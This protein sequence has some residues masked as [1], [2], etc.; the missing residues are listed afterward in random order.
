[1]TLNGALGKPI[2][3]SQDVVAPQTT[4][5]DAYAEGYNGNAPAP[6]TAAPVATRASAPAATTS[7]PARTSGNPF[8][9]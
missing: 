2:S 9:N 3:T 5:Q 6:Q 8:R 4:A 1:M 7:Q